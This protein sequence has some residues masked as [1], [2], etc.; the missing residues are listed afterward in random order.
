MGDDSVSP[1]RE[2]PVR[3]VES[4]E[5]AIVVRLTGEL[6]LYNAEEVRSALATAIAEQPRFVVVD[7]AD[8]EFV[9]SSALGVLLEARSQLGP[10][11]LRLAGP[12]L[13]TRRTLEVSGLDR[14][15]QV[16]ES[17]DAAFS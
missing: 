3:A 8:V 10:N 6:D 11:G 2:P 7:L 13:G 12:Q 4:R 1:L 9:D 17:V 5:G 14:H 15:L 16:H